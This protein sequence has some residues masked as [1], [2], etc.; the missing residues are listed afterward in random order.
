MNKKSILINQIQQL[1]GVEGIE[2]IVV[3]PSEDNYMLCHIYFD[4]E[5]VEER[6]TVD[7]VAS[8]N[9]AATEKRGLIN[10]KTTIYDFNKKL[11]EEI[12]E[13]IDSSVNFEF[14]HSELAD[15]S[16]VCDAMAIHYGID[17][18]KEKELKMKI[19]E[20]RQD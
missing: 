18:P 20:T 16:L 3:E 15:I 13:L 17:L 5:L 1:Y 7:E 2:L 14:D 11:V 4:P 10:S 19:N 12:T 8:R 6:L 9:Y